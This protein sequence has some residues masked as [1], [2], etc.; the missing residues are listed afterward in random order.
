MSRAL[1]AR[2]LLLL[3]LPFSSLRFVETHGALASLVHRINRRPESSSQ[4][5]AITIAIAIHTRRS[6]SRRGKMTP[7]L[8]SFYSSPTTPRPT[9]H[10][11]GDA[12]PAT[13]TKKKKVCEL[14]C[15]LLCLQQMARRNGGVEQSAKTHTRTHTLP[16]SAITSA[17]YTQLL[18]APSLSFQN[19]S[20]HVFLG[21]WALVST[22]A[23][24]QTH[25]RA[26]Q[27][28]QEE[29]RSA[30]Q[31]IASQRSASQRIASQRSALHR[32]AEY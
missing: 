29:E 9:R 19:A 14:Q 18:G 7:H 15:L 20:A 28:G 21:P 4:T 23:H 2:V 26:G 24:T 12:A 13:K 27:G 31:R 32:I 30:S 5:L 8:L 16:C 22:H 10:R 6:I 3:L 25:T 11:L 17:S 1:S